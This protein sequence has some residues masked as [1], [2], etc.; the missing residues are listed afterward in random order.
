MKKQF[1]VSLR[2]IISMTR[3]T[4]DEVACFLILHGSFWLDIQ[5][6]VYSLKENDFVVVNSF[7][8]YQLMSIDD[9]VKENLVLCLDF[10]SESVREYFPGQ[11]IP[12]FHN[13]LNEENRDKG[14]AVLKE[15]LVRIAVVYFRDKES[16][17][18]DLYQY[19][20]QFL[21]NLL[22][23][24][25]SDRVIHRPEAVGRMER[26]VAFIKEHYMDDIT[27]EHI[28]DELDMSYSHCSRLFKKELGIS[29]TQYLN[30]IRLKYAAEELLQGKLPIIKVALNNGFANVKT[31][32][33]L[34]KKTMGIT[35]NE[36]RIINQSKEVVISPEQ[37]DE[38]RILPQFDSIQTLV[39]YLNEEEMEIKEVMV[40]KQLILSTETIQERTFSSGKRIVKINNAINALQADVQNELRVLQ[41]ELEFDLVQFNGFC[42]ESNAYT[43][44]SI[45]SN[46]IYNNIVFDF[47]ME[48]GLKPLIVLKIAKG[49]TGTELKTWCDEQIR[50]VAYLGKRYG[51]PEVNQWYIQINAVSWNDSDQWAYNYLQRELK[52]AANRIHI[53]IL[54]LTGL[55][56]TQYA[57]FT[58]FMN[59]QGELNRLPDFIQFHANPY[60]S[61]QIK[62]TYAK[63]FKQYQSIVLEKL[64]KIIA[65]CVTW[66]YQPEIFLTEWNTLA[67]EGEGLVGTFFRSALIM[68]AMI[69]RADK[70]SGMAFWLNNKVGERSNS[71][72]Q[73]SILSVFMY[74]L[75]RRPVYFCI[76]FIRRLQG[77]VIDVGDGYML[78]KRDGE[79]QLLVYNSS[80]IDPVATVD[81]YQIKIMSEQLNVKLTD[82]DPGVYRIRHYILDKDHGGIYNEWVRAGS[83]EDLD[84]EMVTYLEE[85]IKPKFV[86]VDRRVKEDGDLVLSTILTLNACQ[87]FS[88]RKL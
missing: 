43:D 24:L 32:H 73:D 5:K 40:K 20:L 19:F 83:F 53:G 80:Y 84:Q 41:R 25:R 67:G 39:N 31:F 71:E 63:S 74:R 69:E 78:T 65:G 1:E 18:L 11:Q 29:F 64:N 7:Q 66:L 45:M 52:L 61:L 4:K 30:D 14:T 70:I 76:D 37:K 36:Y 48:V 2:N 47:F 44:L 49:K 68:E 16:E 77:Q 10:N 9:E 6:S 28:A 17:R 62:E 38:V 12:L 55:N 60:T 81:N 56:E 72:F 59:R 57:S 21:S 79:Y 58:D 51:V 75:L 50:M 86:I 15:L 23:Y 54:G 42:W 22:K 26:V 13:F 85:R 46:Y 3:H 33:Q 35:P 8:E 82:I 88:L 27:L 34:F 87:L